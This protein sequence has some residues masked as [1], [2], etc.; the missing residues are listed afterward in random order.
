MN[1]LDEMRT[2][3]TPFGGRYRWPLQFGPDSKHLAIQSVFRDRAGKRD[4]RV[5]IWDCETGSESGGVTGLSITPL[6]KALDRQAELL[7][8]GFNRPAAEG[9]GCEL[10]KV[11]QIAFGG[12]VATW[13]VP[14]RGE[15][16]VIRGPVKG[17]YINATA[18][19]DASRFAATFEA[20]ERKLAVKAWDRTGKIFFTADEDLAANTLLFT[21]L[22]FSRDGNRLALLAWTRDREFRIQSSR[23]R[24]RV[25][26][27]P[28]G[29]VLLHREGDVSVAALSPDGRLI[30]LSNFA[31]AVEDL[32]NRVPA[33]DLSLWDL[34]SGRELLRFELPGA[35]DRVGVL[36]L[37]FSPDGRRLAGSF[38]GTAGALRVWDTASGKAILTRNFTKVCH[39]DPAYSVDGRWLAVSRGAVLEAAVIE[40]VDASSGET[41][42]SLVGHRSEIEKLVFSPDCRRLASLAMS[43]PRPAE[44]KLWD[45]AGGEELLALQGKYGGIWNDGLAFSPDGHLLSYISEARS[46]R[47]DGGKREDA[48]V[49]V[50][51]A[52]PLP[53]G[54][55]KAT[56]VR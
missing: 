8:L 54:Q 2:L 39:G 18:A 44:I 19:L 22:R 23:V 14:P 40:V 12:I 48:Q 15:R 45:V 24:L 52:T 20:A 35:S 53:S 49:Q 5:T 30:A 31:F 16:V 1:S 7:A 6:S 50:W 10:I 51:D 32:K 42:R 38:G 55:R 11:W 47:S 34:D 36:G 3:V 26:D 41:K 29:R 4:W 46:L 28:T 25:W 43:G 21:K 56:G 9:G 13:Q 33:M 27:L 37:T 17:A